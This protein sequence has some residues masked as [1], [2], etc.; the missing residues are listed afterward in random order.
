MSDVTLAVVGLG[1]WAPNLFRCAVELEDVR[2]KAICDDP[3]PLSLGR[4]LV[5]TFPGGRASWA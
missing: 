5:P 4:H 3:L 2:V 1:Y